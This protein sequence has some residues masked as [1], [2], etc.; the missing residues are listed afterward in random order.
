MNREEL[1]NKVRKCVPDLGFDNKYP[2]LFGVYGMT[3]GGICDG[4]YWFDDKL[5]DYG[6]KCGHKPLTEATDI[7]LLE[8]WA[9]TQ[10]YWLGKYTEWLKRSEEKSSKLDYFI[11]YCERMYFGYDKNGYTDKSIDRVFDSIKEILNEHFSYKN[12]E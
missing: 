5:T 11:G 7:E 12:N 10:D 6:R 1:L 2:Q 8:M 9:I 4:F 3:M